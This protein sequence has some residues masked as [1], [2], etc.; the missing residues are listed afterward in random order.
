MGD[1]VGASVADCHPAESHATLEKV[2]RR[3]Y[4]SVRDL[5]QEKKI[6]LRTAA[7]TLGIRRVGRAAMS[8]ATVREEIDFG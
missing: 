3:A 6:D 7:F 8:R 2:M 4:G 1:R 5:A